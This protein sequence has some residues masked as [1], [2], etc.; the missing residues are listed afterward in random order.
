MSG[1]ATLPHRKGYS[2]LGSVGLSYAAC[3]GMPC[4]NGKKKDTRQKKLQ[5]SPVIAVVT[6][7]A[8]HVCIHYS[9]TLTYLGIFGSDV[10]HHVVLST[11][12]LHF[13]PF[14]EMVFASVKPVMC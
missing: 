10:F 3:M 14:L 1:I 8:A 5:M 2:E 7:S 12:F 4:N 13:V 9:V 6:P 11:A